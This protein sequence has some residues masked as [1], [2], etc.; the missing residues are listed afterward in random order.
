M[1]TALQEL[2]DW[3]DNTTIPTGMRAEAYRNKAKELLERE[4]QS[5]EPST[6]VEQIEVDNGN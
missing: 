2:I 6:S 3:M 5:Q 4:K 1:K